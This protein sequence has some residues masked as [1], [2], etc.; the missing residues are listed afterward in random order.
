MSMGKGL[1]HIQTTNELQDVSVVRYMFLSWGKL[2]TN[3]HY[4]GEN[5]PYMTTS[6]SAAHRIIE[7]MYC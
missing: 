6:L 3:V 1:I 7:K 4:I 5:D 2:Y